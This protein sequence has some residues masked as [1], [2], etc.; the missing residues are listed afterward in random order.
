MGQRNGDIDWKSPPFDHYKAIRPLATDRSG[1]A[2]VEHVR[3][4]LYVGRD[5]R[6]AAQ[7]LIKTTSRPGIVYEQNLENE[8]ASLTTINRELP[9]AREFPIVYEHG[10]LRDGRIFLVTSFFDELPLAM[11]IAAEPIP[12]RL[13]MHLRTTLAVARAVG[14]LHRLRIFHVDL[15]PMNILFRVEQGRPWIRLIDFESSYEVARHGAGAFYNPP[16]TPGYSAP[17]VGQRQPDARADVFSLAAVL[18]TMVA[19]YGWTWEDEVGV[20]IARD[21]SLDAELRSLLLAAVAADPAKRTESIDTFS[22]AVAAYL[23]QIWP[24]RSW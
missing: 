1:H 3:H 16:T 19:G 11:S 24:G 2:E 14:E 5:R 6:T 8:L 20:C 17:E 10:R 13:V 4:H 15:N 12:E 7:V 22:A 9:D 21:R 23:E 18:Y